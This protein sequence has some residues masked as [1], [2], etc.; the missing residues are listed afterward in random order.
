MQVLTGTFASDEPLPT[1]WLH[2]SPEGEVIDTLMPPRFS[3]EPSAST[4]RPFGPTKVMGMTALGHLIVGMNDEY[5]FNIRSPEGPVVRVQRDYEPVRLLPEEKSD[6]Q[7]VVDWFKENQPF[8]NISAIPDNKPPYADFLFAQDG[9]IWVRRRAE[10]YK[11]EDD[12]E[13][14]AEES[15]G[16]PP[17]NWRERRVYDVFELDGTYLGEVRFPLRASPL[18]IKA[19]TAW[20]VFRGEFE[21]QYIAKLVIKQD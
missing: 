11:E 10:G 4:F 20:G 16:P 21:E 18:F 2:M 14:A 13:E 7:A 8:A 9:R 3:N 19:D 15:S 17:V 6:W 5:E 1:G 12:E